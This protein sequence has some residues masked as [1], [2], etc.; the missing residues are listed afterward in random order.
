MYWG[1][2]KGDLAVFLR[3][4]IFPSHL[5]MELSSSRWLSKSGCWSIFHTE[6]KGKA[7]P[8]QEK[9][10]DMEV[11]PSSVKMGLGSK[12][13]SL[14]WALEVM[15]RPV[16]CV[17]ACSGHVLQPLPVLTLQG[18]VP[19]LTGVGYRQAAHTDLLVCKGYKR[20]EF[21]KQICYQTAY[22]KF[23]HKRFWKADL[24]FRVYFIS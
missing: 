20:T 21:W 17:H 23:G 5:Y 15:P 1:G 11:L 6:R 24:D 13:V 12:V 8:G 9:P 10:W 3:L 2:N 16:S 7:A 14:L 4:L 22:S 19:V 18:K